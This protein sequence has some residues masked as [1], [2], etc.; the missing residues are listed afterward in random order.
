MNN[1]EF[2]QP[3]FFS[4]DISKTINFTNDELH[5]LEIG[6]YEGKST[7]WFINNALKHK[8]ST[9][10]C[11]DPWLDCIH[12]E[13]SR[14]SYKSDESRDI[15]FNR[16]TKNINETGRVDAVTIERDFS[17]NTLKRL[18]IQQKQYDIMYI[19]GNH[20]SSFVLEDS[21]LSFPLLEKDGYLIWDDYNWTNALAPNNET[22]VPKLAI[23]SFISCYGS[24]INV[25]HKE[26][27]VI[28]QKLI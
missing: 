3:W 17:Y 23:D 10:T 9:I 1:Y 4:G 22:L 28:A 16:F 12:D 2:T 24:Y 6:S 26:Y 21:V 14:T 27:K 7:T 15:I 25:L 11:I 19:D 8:S 5:I 13:T 20:T 18:S